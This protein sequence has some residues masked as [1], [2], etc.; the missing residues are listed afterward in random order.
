[1]NNKD[2]AEVFAPLGTPQLADAALRR[3]VPLRIAPF[4]IGP[5]VPGGRLAGRALPVRHFGSVDIFLEAMQAAAPGDILVIDNGGRTDEGCIGD[6]TVLEARASGLAGLVVWGTHRDTPQLRQIGFSIYSY[7]ACLSGPQRLDQRT[8]DALRLARFG[9][10]EVTRDD[11]VFADDDGCVFVNADGLD[12]I[13][14]TAAAIAR[15]ET[16]QA[17]KISDGERLAAQLKF[18]QYLIRRNSDPAYTFRQH[19]R[20]IGGAI[21]E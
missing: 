19:L 15:T 21:E 5:V 7:G 6:L 16:R 11:F 10:I 9:S 14:K 3:K 20:E 12:E 2:V 1:M 13:L 4:G 18:D 17:Q 8:A